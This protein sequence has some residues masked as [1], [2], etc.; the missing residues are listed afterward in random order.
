MRIPHCIKVAL[1]IHSPCT[2][3]HYTLEFCLDNT[4]SNIT[5]KDVYTLQN[6]TTLHKDPPQSSC[7]MDRRWQDL[8]QR[9]SCQAGHVHA[10]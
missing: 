3:P 7:R 9:L 8:S 5:Y 2:P 4:A 1:S 6:D 10:S